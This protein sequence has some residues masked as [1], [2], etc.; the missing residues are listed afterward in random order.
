MGQR[1]S[2]DFSTDGGGAAG[3]T[4]AGT[5]RI[6][7]RPK[8]GHRYLRLADARANENKRESAQGRRLGSES[9]LQ[10]D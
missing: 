1:P 8:D 2:V 6:F 5:R 7:V 9:L 3:W 4:A 10:S